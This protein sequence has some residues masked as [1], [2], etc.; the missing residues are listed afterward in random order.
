MSG[1]GGLLVGELANDMPSEV[2]VDLAM[3]W[4]G[5][6]DLGSWILIPVVFAAVSDEDTAEFL[7]GLDQI[8]MLHATASSSS[9]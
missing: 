7:H 4:D 2:L 6:G 3:P 9:A 1:T 5:L 8:T